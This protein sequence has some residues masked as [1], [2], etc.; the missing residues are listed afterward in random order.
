MP[1]TKVHVGFAYLEIA[2]HTQWELHLGAKMVCRRDRPLNWKM[3]ESAER[4][5]G[6]TKQRALNLMLKKLSILSICDSTPE[7]SCDFFAKEA[8]LK[9]NSGHW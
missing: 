5:E 6:K 7:G 8:S 3:A 1:G 2:S 4:A 9:W